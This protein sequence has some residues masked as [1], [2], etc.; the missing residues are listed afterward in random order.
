[1]EAAQLKRDMALAKKMSKA[2]A[3]GR[4]KVHQIKTFMMMADEESGV[5]QV[6]N[7]KRK[8]K[9]LFYTPFYALLRNPDGK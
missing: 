4:E 3:M 1:M 6:M 7:L 8:T 5:N 9:T 2:S